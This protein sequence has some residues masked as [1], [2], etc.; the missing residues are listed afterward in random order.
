MM[1]IGLDSEEIVFE[2]LRERVRR[3]TDKELI[4]SG[5]NVRRLTENPFQRNW[6]RRERSGSEGNYIKVY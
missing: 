3:I 2:K 5:K 6:I 1:S 4:E